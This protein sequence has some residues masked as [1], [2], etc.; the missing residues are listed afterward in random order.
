MLTKIKIFFFIPSLRAGGAEKVVS[1]I[2]QKID[3]T[4]FE[5]TLYVIGSVND[6]KLAVDNVNVVFLNYNR[7]SQSFL[8]IF[9]IIKKEKPNIVFGT[10][11]HVNIL[12]GF[13]KIFFS[14]ICFI[15][16]EVNVI[17]ILS[18]IQKSN[19]FVPKWVGRFLLNKLD[20]IVC[21]SIDMA[22]DVKK[23]FKISEDKIVIINNPISNLYKLKSL[24]Q[25][26]SS[27]FKLI[28]VASLT[29]R[30]GHLRILEVLKDLKIDFEYTIVGDGHLKKEILTTINKYNLNNRISHIP[31][32][33]QVQNLLQ[34]NDLFLLGSFVE[35][36]PNVLLES[37]AVG[38][39]V[40]AFDAPGG[41]NEI[42]IDGVNGY[43][44]KNK[45]DYLEKIMISK[46]K[47]WDI[48]EIRDS[49][50]DRYNEDK[51]ISNYEN[52]F[53][54]QINLINGI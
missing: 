35:G 15:G 51:I 43:I 17:S 48:Q 12:L 30:K 3:K 47:D 38:T 11:G 24:N 49:V 20:I 50:M 19:S 53:L 6:A 7:V 42:I 28:T 2:A 9:K 5:S 33:N 32:S 52:L 22:I 37:C 8:S 10:I 27:T 16:R 13:Y 46:Q 54:S 25:L 31:F 21:Q 4:K 44:A 39:P 14:K 26:T 29:S 1:F 34:N 40:I 36:F 41:I 23:L 18:E 45:E